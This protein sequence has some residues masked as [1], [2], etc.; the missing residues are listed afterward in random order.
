MSLPNQKQGD[1]G[2]GSKKDYNLPT[3]SSV[4]AFEI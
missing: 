3:G 2:S 1:S 4:R